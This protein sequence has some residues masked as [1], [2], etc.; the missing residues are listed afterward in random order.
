MGGE[1]LVVVTQSSAFFGNLFYLYPQKSKQLR[2][3]LDEVG[4]KI[5][6]ST[7][8]SAVEI[9][10]DRSSERVVGCQPNKIKKTL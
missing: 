4:E 1:H 3:N 8:K 6:L 2:R 7:M 9:H 5:T 10:F